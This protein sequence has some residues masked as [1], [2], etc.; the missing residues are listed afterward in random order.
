[1][2]ALI[3]L[4]IQEQEEVKRLKAEARK[5]LLHTTDMAAKQAAYKPIL[6]KM[7]IDGY[8]TTSGH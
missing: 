7:Y 8:S 2:S 3:P 4:T 6:K 1:M 5:D